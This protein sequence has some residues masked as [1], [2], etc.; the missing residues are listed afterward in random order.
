M[1]LTLRCVPGSLA[2]FGLKSLTDC[3]GPMHGFMIGCVRCVVGL[4]CVDHTFAWS[5]SG[6]AAFGTRILADSSVDAVCGAC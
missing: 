3:C 5:S 4:M 1:H 2:L 6:G